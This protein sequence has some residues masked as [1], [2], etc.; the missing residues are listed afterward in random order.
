MDLS[1][2]MRHPVGV[3]LVRLDAKTGALDTFLPANTIDITD[4]RH[5]L[6]EP[7]ADVDG[8]LTSQLVGWEGWD[9]AEWY[10]TTTP[11]PTDGTAELVGSWPDALIRIEF[12]LRTRRPGC[13]LRR[14]I[15][16]F[17]ELG[18]PAPEPGLEHVWLREDI[19]CGAIPP[20]G[21]AVDGTLL[22]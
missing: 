15:R 7:P 18:R 4:H 14:D 19:A 9:Q 22:M 1:V 12:N 21:D 11:R 2:P 17:D 13:R 20:S 3:D 16:L 8:L 5:P 10:Q 6:P